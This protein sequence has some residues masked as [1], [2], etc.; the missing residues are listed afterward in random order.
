MIGLTI[1]L[2]IHRLVNFT[3]D[4]IIP[5]V[6]TDHCDHT[7]VQIIIIIITSNIN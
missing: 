4:P 5:S 1:F 3:I 6:I 7:W 2:I